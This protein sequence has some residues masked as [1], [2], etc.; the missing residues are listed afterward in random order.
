MIKGR[1]D[2][3]CFSEVTLSGGPFKTSQV[4]RRTWSHDLGAASSPKLTGMLCTPVHEA[5]R[6]QEL[7]GQDSDEV[8]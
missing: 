2:K 8:F 7:L 4:H 3:V 6:P 5:G 1:F